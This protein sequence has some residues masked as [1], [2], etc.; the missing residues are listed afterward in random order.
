VSEVEIVP[1]GDRWE[2]AHRAFASA[3][4]P[5]KGR[6]ASAS[7]MR[8]KF[9]GPASGDV[10]HLILAVKEGAVVGQ[11]GLVPARLHAAGREFPLF[12][13]CDL[14]VE[15]AQRRFGISH[16]MF[17]EA[18]RRTGVFLGSD[19]SPSARA[20]MAKLGYDAFDSSSIAVLPLRP[21]AVAA[22]RYP[23][24]APVAGVLEAA[25]APV[26]AVRLRALRKGMKD[27]RAQLCGWRDVVDDVAAHDR[28]L[29]APHQVHDAAFLEWRCGGLEGRVKPAEA[30][31]TDAGSFVVF[32]RERSRVVV[33]Q[34]RAGT[35]ADLRSIFG[36]LLY[37]AEAH[38][39]DYVQTYAAGPDQVAQLKSVG[40]S[41]RRTP[42][43]IVARVTDVEPDGLRDLVFMGYDSDYGL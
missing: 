42:V 41:L 23:K 24:L 37:V 2:E 6:R 13:P 34:W 27:V 26:L 28:S 36:R 18:H 19:P 5:G 30:I 12:W 16:L 43:E 35:D 17:A 31:R 39:V 29:G 38:G 21:A 22:I 32:E 9:R 3:N 15:P 1:Y 14:M 11:L 10:E 8:W 7:Y 20:S 25:A 33:H 4:Y 40:F